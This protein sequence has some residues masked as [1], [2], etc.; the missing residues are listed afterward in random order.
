M[1]EYFPAQYTIRLTVGSHAARHIRRIVRSFLGEWGMPE[2]SDAVEL[3]VTELLAN[4]VRHVPDRRCALLLLRQP[5]GV[6]VEVTD[7]SNRLPVSPPR[8]DPDSENGRGLLLLDAM[9]DKWGVSVWSEGGKTVWFEC[10]T[11]G[12]P[13]HRRLTN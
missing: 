2:L 7:G 13:C 6:R 11:E 1:N 5:T 4:V 3:G 8:V 9:A 12:L 10:G